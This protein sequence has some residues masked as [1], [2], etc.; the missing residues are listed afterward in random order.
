MSDDDCPHTGKKTE[1]ILPDG[2]IVLVC[3]NCGF[4]I[5]ELAE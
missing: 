4:K 3:A 1:R 5:G 2:T